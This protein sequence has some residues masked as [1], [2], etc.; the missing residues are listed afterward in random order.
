[1]Q[2]EQVLSLPLHDLLG[3]FLFFLR[4]FVGFYYDESASIAVCICS[5]ELLN[6][7]LCLNRNVSGVIKFFFLPIISKEY[8]YLNL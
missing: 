1:M 6:N 7:A 2:L 4:I 5:F 3:I 8:A